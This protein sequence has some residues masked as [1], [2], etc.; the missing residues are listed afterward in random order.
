MLPQHRQLSDMLAAKGQQLGAGMF[1]LS[2]LDSLHRLLKRLNFGDITSNYGIMAPSTQKVSYAGQVI[3]F[4][5]DYHRK[6]WR[7]HP[8]HGNVIGKGYTITLPTTAE[9]HRRLIKTYPG[10][11]FVGVYEAGF[12]GFQIV[13]QLEEYGIKMHA[14]HAADVPQ[15]DKDRQQKSDPIDAL[16]LAKLAVSG[17]YEAV[18]VP[19]LSEEH[20]RQLSRYRKGLV[21]KQTRIK[22]QIKSHLIYIGK[23]S[24][25]S[26]LG[27][28]KF[29]QKVVAELKVLAEQ[30]DDSVGY[31][32]Y[33]LLNLLDDLEKHHKRIVETT[34]ELNKIVKEQQ[35][36]LYERLLGCPGVGPLT[37]M[38][39]IA[40]LCNMNRFSSADK[41]CSYVGLM[42]RMSCSG[43]KNHHGQMVDR[44][45]KR[46][47]TALIEAAWQAK[48]ADAA[49]SIYYAKLIN[50]EKL[51]SNKAIVKVARKLLNRIRCIWITGQEYKKNIG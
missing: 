17:H 14:V 29:T 25:E 32:D 36:E 41:L 8:I 38:T 10:A 6:S 23:L 24:D 33:T 2:S 37:A 20:F 7:V 1:V 15:T 47:R 19:T 28:W 4:G 35:G 30:V 43:D 18:Y 44:G 48:N 12:C 26:R 5:L 13:R 51:T 40:E 9:L 3:H 46:V 49:L 34:K 16:R 11:T 22:N 21:G 27:D 45:N 39:L 31:V 42:P 50:E